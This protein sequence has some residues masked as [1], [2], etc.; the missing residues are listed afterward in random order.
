M[1]SNCEEWNYPH[2]FE[3]RYDEIEYVD[4]DTTNDRVKVDN[5]RVVKTYLYDICVKCG[6]IIKRED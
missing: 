2:D 1:S 4:V 5:K 3:P 6:K